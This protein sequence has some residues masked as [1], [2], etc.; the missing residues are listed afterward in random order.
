MTGQS[1]HEHRCYFWRT[2][3]SALKIL[4]SLFIP[5]AIKYRKLSFESESLLVWLEAGHVSVAIKF[6]TTNA[7]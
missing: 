6:N 2:G 5:C 3:K 7:N 1:F 4:L